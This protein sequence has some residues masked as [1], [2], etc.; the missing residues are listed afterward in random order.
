MNAAVEKV[1]V[2]RAFLRWGQPWIHVVVEII[3][4]L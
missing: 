1:N 4:D 3:E 2:F